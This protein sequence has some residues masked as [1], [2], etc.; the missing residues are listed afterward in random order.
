M[1]LVRL[2]MSIERETPSNRRR[3]LE[4]S[5]YASARE[6]ATTGSTREARC[7]RCKGWTPN[8][9]DAPIRIS[10]VDAL[11]SRPFLVQ[12]AN[13]GDRFIRGVEALRNLQV[14]GARERQARVEH[15]RLRPLDESRPHLARR[16]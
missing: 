11:A 14:L 4:R 2:D 1:A 16:G 13:H 9:R 6:A 8:I 15:R 3:Q 10:A 5:D 7:A 12:V